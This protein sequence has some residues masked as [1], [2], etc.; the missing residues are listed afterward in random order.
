VTFPERQNFLQHTMVLK[1]ELLTKSLRKGREA[2]VSLL[3]KLSHVGGLPE[4]MYEYEAGGS[5]RKPSH[6]YKIRF[7]AP[8][9]LLDRLYQQHITG[10]GR[11][12]QKAYARTLAALEVVHQIEE[13]MS[14]SREGLQKLIDDI[15]E[16]EAAKKA[17]F[18]EHPITEQLPGVS[19]ENVPIDAAFQETNPAGRKG[20]IEFFPDLMQNPRA[21]VAAKLLTITERE[22][23]P[24][25]A[26]HANQTD[27]GVL[28]RWANI[29]S[30]G[31]VKGCN[32]PQ[33]ELSM[34]ASNR[35]AEIIGLQSI[36]Y[37]NPLPHDD[38]ISSP[39]SV[40]PKKKR[41]GG[42]KK[43]G[44]TPHHPIHDPGL[45]RLVELCERY[46]KSFG[47]AKL[48][49]NLPKHHFADLK[50]LVKNIAARFI[51]RDTPNLTINRQ[52]S[53][54][55]SGGD[56]A[57]G[58]NADSLKARLAK[59]R[60]HQK[61]NPLPVDSV[62]SKIPHE[63]TVTIVRGGTGSG[64][65]TRYPLMLSLFSPSGASTKVLV[66]QPRRLACQSAAKR[67]A[68]EQGF[69]IGSSG[70]PIGYAIRFESF[71]ST[72]EDRS[73]DFQTP[74]VLLR[75][76]TNDPLLGDITHLC[77]D[78]V[79]E[80]NADIDLLLALAKQVQKKRR[81]HPTL[82]PLRVIL[83][84]ATLDSSQWESYFREGNDNGR[85][86]K[87]VDVPN[88]RRFPI[89]IHHLDDAS[90]PLQSE[91]VQRLRKGRT[92]NADN[93]DQDLCQATAS[94]ALE[95]YMGN[96]LKGGSILCF[97]PGME[98][99]RMVHQLL[100]RQ[101]GRKFLDVRHLHSSLS[102]DA[103]AKVFEPGQKIILST[104][105]A[106]TS[107]TIPDVKAVIDGGRERQFSMLASSSESDSTTVVGS[108]LA[109]VNI[110]QASAKQRAGRAGRVSAGHC[111]R[112]YTREEHETD[113]LPFTTP[114]M[115]RMDLSQLLLHALSLTNSSSGHPLTL[116]LGAPDPPTESQLRKTI[117]GLA[118]QGLVD[119]SG[120]GRG[121]IND[122]QADH[123]AIRLTPLG[124]AVSSLPADPR[125]AR[126][127]YMGLVLRAI[128]PALTIA[129]LLS[130]PKVFS[131]TDRRKDPS[132][133]GSDVMKQF[134]A[135]SDYL[136]GED[137]DHDRGIIFG[138]VARVRRQL[139]RSMMKFLQRSKTTI[140]KDLHRATSDWNANGHRVGA[141][142]GLIC[143]AT[144]HIAHLVNGQFDF[145]TR[146][147]AGG[148]RIH[149]ASTNFGKKAKRAHWYVYHEL[150]TTKLPYLHVTTAVSPL[151][152]ALF[153][154]WS[155]SEP[156]DKEEIDDIE[157]TE[158]DDWCFVA[159]QWVPV[160]VSSLG[161]RA[162]FMRLKQLLMHDILQQVAQDPMSVLTDSDY[163]KLV[164]Y[165]LSA[166]EQHR[167][168]K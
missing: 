12:S 48:F 160:D 77:I 58:N 19:W 117:Q 70:C 159:D 113:F 130:V 151:E 120:L 66:V 100:M 102:S 59:F 64:K 53:Y 22:G 132:W 37:S 149:P 141:Q 2:A 107:V 116:L 143:G 128:D 28:Q 162:T 101:R 27:S 68:F 36:L 88:V 42:K 8:K 105:I 11:A 33:G 24:A 73:V 133:C 83:M 108:Q 93:Y 165:V 115:L 31:R 14:V 92:R 135:Y 46:D 4:P 158:N 131:S 97:L 35:D 43:K 61:K 39:A 168:S 156:D 23:L 87:V 104:N 52:R 85:N 41:K 45:P 81:N 56:R 163:E 147:V 145:A 72:S 44:G 140:D 69:R 154:D 167:L 137:K 80:R 157:L 17:L 16:K 127:L 6:F 9:F 84:S 34:G 155:S 95:L 20:R 15:I 49:V 82:P 99:I 146:D 106:E 3:Q 124:R 54:A 136:K 30:N 89:E 57:L 150:R 7:R 86:I 164:L 29:G 63:A 71:L 126:M 38:V 62:E 10:A 60:S 18:E 96:T 76:A 51:E 118:Y 55:R 122:A 98:E 91:L 26:I 112:L 110:S 144:P 166:I 5:V 21:L 119:V 74:G 153:S 32:G 50:V 65:T 79:H 123:T 152:L 121:S 103:Q 94:L 47:M 78:E 90:F 25:I 142:V 138:Q 13:D 139:E 111:Y 129:A 1:K 161:Q 125:I 114:E 134:N 75:R 40:K 109:T 67:V 148:A